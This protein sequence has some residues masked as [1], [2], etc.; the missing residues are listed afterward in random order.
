V[1][2]TRTLAF[3]GAGGDQLAGRLDLP[4]GEPRAVVLVAHC[5]SGGNAGPAA[6][7]IARSFNELGM[8]VLSLDFAR[9][10]QPG[11]MPTSAMFS[12]GVD[13][14][15]SAAAKLRSTLAAPSIL[16]GHSLGGAAVLAIAD[17]V[18]E[19]RAVVTLAT[20]ADP[21]EAAGLGQVGGRAQRQRIATLHRAL[22]VIHS[23]DDE[24]VSFGDAEVIFEATRHPK[25]FISL[26]GADHGLTRPADASYVASV[27]AA[28]AARY[29]PAPQPPDSETSP[30]GPAR[31]DVVVVTE[32]DARP[33]GQRI[34]AG[35]HQV[36]ADEPAAIGGADSGPTPYDLLLAGLGACTAITVRMYADRKGWPLRQTTV[37]LR[38]QRIHAK[39]CADCETRTGQMD[40]IERELQFEGELTDFQRA[41][42]LDIAERCPV[43]R[44]LHS[45][46][47]V[48][49]AETAPDGPDGP[50]G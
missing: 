13:D 47:L 3:A 28:W 1:T 49:T 15:A 16:V 35:G 23:P 14:L 6:A 40:Q 33:Y 46:V 32:S 50:A 8:A 42:L 4:D 39:D 25:S 19:A 45:E 48:S 10:P 18:P 31:H 9:A 26:D 43:H 27:M 37:R 12:L 29:L 36:V 5:F 2:E 44:T 20:P 17:Q 22:L 41:R 21:A 24:V 30:A 7:Q 11:G 34:T 38:H